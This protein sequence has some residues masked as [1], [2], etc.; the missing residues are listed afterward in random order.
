MTPPDFLLRVPPLKLH[1]RNATQTN[2]EPPVYELFCRLNKTQ[3]KQE[4]PAEVMQWSLWKTYE[5][6]QAFDNQMRAARKSTF[7]KMMVTVA[8]APGHR[9]RAFFHQDQT[10]GFL[11][12]RRAELDFYIQRVMLFPD[13]AD[14]SKGGCKVLADFIGAEL[15]MDCSGLAHPTSPTMH[16]S[17][18]FASSG[19]MQRGSYESD[20]RV[21]SMSAAGAGDKTSSRRKLCRLEIEEEITLRGGAHELKRF[22]KRAR[23]FRKENDPVAAVDPF[24]EFVQKEYDPDFSSWI[25]QRFVRSL[26]SGEKRDALCAASGVSMSSVDDEDD[27]ENRSQRQNRRLSV[28]DDEMER[29]S[30][31]FAEQKLQSF[32]SSQT[33]MGSRGSDPAVPVKVSRKKANRQILEHVNSLS[34][35]NMH[36]V[37]EFKQAAKALGNQEMSGEAF[38]SYLR[39]TFGKKAA[40]ELL[41]LVVEVIPQPQ[42][43][44]ELRIALAR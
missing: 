9:V 14:F 19:G 30:K 11:E 41:V 29:Q 6:F 44:Q 25:L 8:F 18:V 24:V 37:D 20:A 33:S 21:S 32:S 10:A 4:N 2:G 36:V 43:Q 3:E 42:V 13:V 38:V 31:R 34:N 5:E 22:K 1:V 27:L 35:G 7:A 15:Y 23:A 28:Q 12:K 17:G 40:E 26:K 16:M 39:S